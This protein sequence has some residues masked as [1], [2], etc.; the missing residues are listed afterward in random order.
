[1]V[2]VNYLI[3]GVAFIFLMEVASKYTDV[4]FSNLERFILICLW[5]VVFVNFIWN[6]LKG[7]YNK[8]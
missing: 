4:K 5:P 1:M 8:K 3:I 2:I 7:Y 6:V